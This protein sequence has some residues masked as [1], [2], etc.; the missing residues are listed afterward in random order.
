MKRRDEDYVGRNVLKWNYD[1]Q[2]N[3]NIEMD[4]LYKD[5][6]GRFWFKRGRCNGLNFKKKRHSLWQP[7]E[8]HFG[9]HT[10]KRFPVK[11]NSTKVYSA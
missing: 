6:H 4:R 8:G 10:T 7:C 1:D 9:F 11:L 3:V 5:S 2:R